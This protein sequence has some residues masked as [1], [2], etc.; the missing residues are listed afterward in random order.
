MM[1]A[2]WFTCLGQMRLCACRCPIL[3]LTVLQYHGRMPMQACLSAWGGYLHIIY[4]PD[5]CFKGVCRHKGHILDTCALRGGYL[6]SATLGVLLAECC[7]DKQLTKEKW[8][9]VAS[10]VEPLSVLLLFIHQSDK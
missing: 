9:P 3:M 8:A 7:F 5:S 2:G 1:G 4:P 10:L 6:G